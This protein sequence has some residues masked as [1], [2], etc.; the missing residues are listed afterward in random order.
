MN[1]SAEQGTQNMTELRQFDTD[2]K[3]L[4]EYIS[5]L[6]TSLDRYEYLKESGVPDVILYTEKGL[7]DQ[8][9]LFFSK[10]WAKLTK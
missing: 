5:L 9:L 1:V 2:M 8:Q 3:S 6:K 7:I 10:A 4:H